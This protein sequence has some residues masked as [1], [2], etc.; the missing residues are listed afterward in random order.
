MRERQL[1]E[2]DV[3]LDVLFEGVLILF[4]RFIGLDVDGLVD[5]LG[6]VSPGRPFLSR[7]DLG[8][9]AAMV[10]VGGSSDDEQQEDGADGQA[11]A[12]AFI[13][14]VV[15]SGGAARAGTCPTACTG[16]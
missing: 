16:P 13:Q 10:H 3:D 6:E 9:L 15:A 7:L 1:L 4:V 12:A 8:D 5:C 11:A 2:L 14:G